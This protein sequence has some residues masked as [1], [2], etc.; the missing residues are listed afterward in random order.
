MSLLR[1]TT[2]YRRYHQR[3]VRKEKET[4]MI[5]NHY[6]LQEGEEV[7]HAFS[8]ALNKNNI[9]FWLEFG[10]LLGY[11][12]EHDFI[13]HDCDIDFGVFLKDRDCV[14]SALE[15]GGFKLIHQFKSSD[16]GMEETYK[17][18]HISVDVFYFREDGPFLYCN[19]F[20]SRYPVFLNRVTKRRTCF[21]KRIDIPNQRMVPAQY[22]GANVFVPADC[23]SH[24][25]MHYGADFMI[26]NPNFDY[27][28]EA[29][30]IYY[31]TYKERKG[32]LRVYEE[33]L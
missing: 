13:K 23:E 10:S 26:P 6:F 8:D 5:R 32:R 21:V 15:R 11:Y 29:T 24:L 27:K 22:K 14:N 31:Y 3:N 18:K 16:G 9:I 1:K 33:K 28:K 19:T 25:K 2:I 30:N 17:Y 20:I 12:R 4:L 7:L